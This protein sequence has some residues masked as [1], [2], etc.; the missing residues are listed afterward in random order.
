MKFTFDN[1]TLGETESVVY[2]IRQETLLFNLTFVSKAIEVQSF[3]RGI[4]IDRARWQGVCIHG[5][6]INR[7]FNRYDCSN[8][9]HLLF[10][11]SMDQES[12]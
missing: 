4:L 10:V 6:I 12:F 7:Y 5:Q 3:G 2:L 9:K 11:G 1:L 8:L